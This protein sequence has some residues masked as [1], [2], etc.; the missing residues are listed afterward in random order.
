M[1]GTVLLADKNKKLRAVNE[2]QKRKRAVRKKQISKKTTLTVA[3]AQSLI[4]GP[5]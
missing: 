5:L 4:R 2:R 1:H 3:E